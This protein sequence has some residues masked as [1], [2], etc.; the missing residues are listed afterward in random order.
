MSVSE[1]RG[2]GSLFGRLGVGTVIN[3]ADTYTTLGGGPL[4]AEVVDAMVEASR[5]HVDIA[6]LLLRSGEHLARLTRNEAA[7]VVNG[8]AAGLAVS[9]AACI[10]GGSPAGVFS[11]PRYGGEHNEVVVFRC[12]RNPYDRAITDAGAALVEIGYATGTPSWQ[13]GSA[14]SANTAAIVYFAGTQF[15]QYAPALPSVIEL[16]G[17]HGVPVVVDAAAQIPPVDNLWAY[18]AMGADLVIFSGGKGLRGP[19]AS[20]LMVGRRDLVSAC[21][22]HAYPNHALG[23][24]MKTTKECIAGLV[25]AVERAV[26]L[27]WEGERRRQ[28]ATVAHVVRAVSA[29]SGVQ[30]WRAPTGRLG[31]SYPR[32]FLRWDASVGPSVQVLA[33]E[34]LSERPPI[35]IGTGEGDERTAYVNPFTLGEGEVQLV[36]DAI[37]RFF[38]RRQ[39]RS[40]GYSSGGRPRST[41][42]E[43]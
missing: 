6:D 22:A 32:A 40:V 41:T 36:V 7:L 21:A 43:S 25:A 18:S 4:P 23:R 19:Q 31:Q 35:Y 14:L 24:S 10:A 33:E 12:Q 2:D 5:H 29:L 27:D 17:Q 28:E 42:G 3:A 16:A 11:A 34:L 26:G 38:A 9:T 30:A 37:A 13:L 39:R 8:A 15:E 20:G 1:S